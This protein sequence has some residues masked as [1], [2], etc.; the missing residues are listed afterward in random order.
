MD[1]CWR[2]NKNQFL[3]A[4]FAFLVL[5]RIVK[6][7]R[8][9][10]LLVGHTHE[11]IDSTFSNISTTLN[12]KDVF[13]ID[14]L[15]QTIKESFQK[16][17]TSVSLLKYV[18]NYRDWFMPNIRTPSHH[19]EPHAY[20]FELVNEEVDLSFK[21]F[22]M[23]PEWTQLKPALLSH[24]PTGPIP[25]VRFSWRKQ[26]PVDEI[27][28]KIQSCSVKLPHQS[29]IWW[30]NFTDN[31]RK[32]QMK[33]SEASAATLISDGGC[34]LSYLKPHADVV[35][36]SKMSEDDARRNEHIDMLMEKSQRTPRT[37]ISK[38]SER[39]KPKKKKKKN[40]TETAN[41]NKTNKT[42]KKK[43]NNETANANK[44]NKKKNNKNEKDPLSKAKAR[45]K[46]KRALKVKSRNVIAGKGAE[47]NVMN[48]S[49]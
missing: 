16:Q 32:E 15:L 36:F 39:E 25:L 1:N 44:T 9:S 5:K 19:T 13:T 3:L 48:V 18:F 42:N 6:K 12:K 33:W 31:L 4:F 2:E 45:V 22:A 7:V 10:Y 41:E 40:P 49:L 43:K 47:K 26:L 21:R 28:E 24:L 37:L 34:F 17:N 38:H 8:L 14:H 46:A 30:G 29:M 11:D 23:D 27:E 35:P 20:K